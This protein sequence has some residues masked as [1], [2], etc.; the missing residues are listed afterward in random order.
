MSKKNNQNLLAILVYIFG[1]MPVVGQLV[2]LLILLAEKRN[3]FIRFHAMQSLVFFSLVIALIIILSFSL[4]G[5]III[6]F[7]LIAEFVLWL[8]FLWK[9]Y[10][11]EMFEFP[12][13][14]SFSYK[15]LKKI[16]SRK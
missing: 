2:S 7:I 1:P 4:I 14:G 8:L 5:L 11:G 6:P 15:Q 3:K 10:R 9:A 16:K 13:V 12:F